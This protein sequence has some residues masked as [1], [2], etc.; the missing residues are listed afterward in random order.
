MRR[1]DASKLLLAMF[2]TALPAIAVVVQPPSVPSPVPGGHVVS[3]AEWNSS[4]VGAY[5]LVNTRICNVLNVLTTKG[6]TYAFDGTALRALSTGA[7][8]TVAIADSTTATGI[9]WD[10]TTGVTAVTTVGDIEVT[11]G[12]VVNRLPVGQDGYALVADSASSLGMSWKSLANSEAFPRGSIIAFSP[13]FAGANTVDGY[14][15]CDGTN[16]TPNLIGRFV[17]GTRPNGSSASASPGGFGAQSVN[18][19]GAGAATHTQTFALAGS[20]NNTTTLEA[21]DVT[22]GSGVGTVVCLPHTHSITPV[23]SAGAATNQPSD[24]ALV[25]LMKL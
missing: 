2:L 13:N 7:N 19:N 1:S 10:T 22:C 11:D 23:A 9:K 21:G 17:L 8:D 6:D 3:A 18:G 4:I 14:A 12:R 24:Y 5:T 20:P 16:G 25:Y 15:L